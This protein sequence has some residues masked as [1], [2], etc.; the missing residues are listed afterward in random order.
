M[1]LRKTPSTEAK[2]LTKC[3]AGKTLTVLAELNNWLKVQ[4]PATGVI[5]YIS[6]KYV[7][8]A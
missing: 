3:Y 5:G 1:N 2:V 6:S 8:R 4:D 7:S